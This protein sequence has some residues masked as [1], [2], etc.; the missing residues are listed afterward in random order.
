VVRE[1]LGHSAKDG[2]AAG[3]APGEALGETV[4]AG[5]V[6]SK[7]VVRSLPSGVASAPLRSRSAPGL[8][9]KRPVGAAIRSSTA[10]VITIEPAHST[11]IARSE[12][13]KPGMRPRPV[14]YF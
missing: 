12:C 10:F 1:I 13:R 3:E 8:G 9:Q 11:R 4:V 7:V 2:G 5:T 6:R 14:Q